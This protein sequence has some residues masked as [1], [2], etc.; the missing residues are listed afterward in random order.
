MQIHSH[1]MQIHSHSWY[2]V[3][4]LQEEPGK[5]ES[6]GTLCFAI[7]CLNCTPFL[8]CTY[9]YACCSNYAHVHSA[10]QAHNRPYMYFNFILVGLRMFCSLYILYIYV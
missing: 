1:E 9:V 2:A 6:H 4:F 3:T 5:Q 8:E 10:K 7:V